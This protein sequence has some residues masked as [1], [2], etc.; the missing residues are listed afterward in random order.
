MPE[1]LRLA[2][3]AYDA[4]VFRDV[5]TMR[6]AKELILTP[7]LDRTSLQRWELE[8]P[9]LADLID[10]HV[11]LDQ[12]S[13][14]LDYGCGIGRMAKELIKRHDCLVLG[15]DISPNMRGLAAS[16]VESD[17]FVAFS[18]T[19]LSTFAVKCDLALAVWVLQHCCDPTQELHKIRTHLTSAGRLFVVNEDGHRWVPTTSGWT[20]DDIDVEKEIGRKFVAEWRGRMAEDVVGP[21]TSKR[22]FV[23][24]YTKKE[25]ISEHSRR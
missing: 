12:S 22:T 23:A 19:M 4:S 21:D 24:F 18:P 6:Q 7:D 5:A 20:D 16:Y 8:T 17:R 3:A 25:M 1:A 15:V 9:Y 11:K 13:I 10:E 2:P 14:V